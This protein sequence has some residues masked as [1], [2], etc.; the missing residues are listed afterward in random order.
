MSFLREMKPGAVGFVWLCLIAC[1]RTASVEG[2]TEVRGPL[3]LS[4]Q[5]LPTDHMECSRR[6]EKICQAKGKS[7]ADCHNYIL[8][9][10]FM[11]DSRIYV[12]GTYAFDPHCAFISREGFSLELEED[13]S[14]RVET[15]KGRCPF[16]PREQH[17][18]VMADGILYSATTNNF[19]GTTPLISRA[20]GSEGE[21]VRTEE[22]PSWLSAPVFVGS[23]WLRM[24]QDN[25]SGEDD[26][27]LF[28]FTEV[29]EE[30][31]FYRKIRA[32]RVARVCKGDVGGMK[33]L[34]KRWTSFLKAGLVCE[35]GA[36]GERYNILRDVFT[37][38]PGDTQS[39]RFYAVFS[40][41]EQGDVS[42][43]C[44]YSA[45]DIST[46]MEG[47]FKQ[48]HFCENSA[49][50]DPGLHPHPGQCITSSLKA[51]GFE[52]S[53]GLPDAVLN[54]M[55]DHHLM[56]NSLAAAPL[57]VRR[58]ITYT[59]IAVTMMPKSSGDQSSTVILHL[60]T[61]TGEL[62][63]VSVG[64]HT[65]TLL[66]EVPLFNNPVNNILIHQEQ[67]IVSS[68]LS[69]AG[70]LAEGCRMYPSCEACALVQRH[71]CI[72]REGACT[73]LT[74]GEPKAERPQWACKWEKGHCWAEAEVQVL[75]V[76]AGL[77]LLLPCVQVS[78]F[79]CTWTHPPGRHTR[80][81][82]CDLAVT[83]TRET[84]GSYTCLCEEGGA[85]EGRVQCRRAAYELVLEDPS[86]GGN[87]GPGQARRS[88]GL[89]LACL[90]LGFLLGAFLMV[91]LRKRRLP[92]AP[93]Y[94]RRG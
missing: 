74:P 92:T 3:L 9:L 68:S 84:V 77:R 4:G 38:Q 8:V 91:I 71:G 61:D 35:D 30:Y 19:M 80:Q 54:F 25:P 67:L 90:F 56:E 93:S 32:P 26:Q 22:S 51:E 52:S 12:C 5:H 23:A 70:V 24:I 7:E 1:S 81:Q 11:S 27:L 48:Q 64:G 37:L 58:G 69:L 78:P 47:P 85:G 6:A 49:N 73:P 88:L 50:P 17:T 33:T 29:G 31:N 89:Y 72:W 87:W 86:A 13:G 59:K 83:V 44:V 34:Q 21:R 15:G 79:P 39:T 53:L 36:S 66:Q 63:R 94:R 14:V 62:H 82:H 65:A 18:A 45:A 55:R 41:E 28:F 10:D 2:S 20:T 40:S 42:A 57:L 75:Q 46:V 16:D 43:V 60:G 76:R